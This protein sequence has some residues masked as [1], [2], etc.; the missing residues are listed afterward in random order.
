M[1]IF[2]EMYLIK[3]EKDCIKDET[4]EIFWAIAETFEFKGL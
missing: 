3:N 2:G 1:S 4:S